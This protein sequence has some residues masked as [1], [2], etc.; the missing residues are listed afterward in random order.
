[1]KTKN[2]QLSL[3]GL[4]MLLL[5]ACEKITP[6]DG[7]NVPIPVKVEIKGLVLADTLEFVLDNVV[8]GQAIESKF[9]IA[10]RL[11]SPGKKIHF[12]KKADGRVL[13]EYVVE[14][15][16]YNQVK[17][18]FYDGTKLMDKVELIPVSNPNNVG[19]RLRFVTSFPD[20]YGGPVDVEFFLMTRTTTR[21]RV[22]TYTSIKLVSS[23]TGALSGFYELPA[24][25][26]EPGF[27]KSYQV[28]VYKAGTT[29]LPY[30]SFDKVNISD[31][32]VNYGE[33][34]GSLTAGSS[35]LLS[36]S[37]NILDDEYIGDGYNIIDLAEDFQ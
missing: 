19:F 20:F 25:V 28:K 32:T 27:I 13:G 9:S 37:P 35:K 23:V 12:R 22:T 3:V 31:Q 18:I 17:K 21:P 36:I 15:E 29:E 33:I 1:M 8:I 10:D 16:P 26:E 4:C 30:R 7:L 24:I 11:Y 2:I 6:V 14:S 5:Y 34:I